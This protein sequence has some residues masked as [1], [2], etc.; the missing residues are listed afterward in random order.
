MFLLNIKNIH[1]HKFVVDKPIIESTSP[2][3]TKIGASLKENVDLVC[4]A[5]GYPIPDIQWNEYTSPNSLGNDYNIDSNKMEFGIK[6]TL[7]FTVQESHFSTKFVCKAS[8]N[9]GNDQVI[10]QVLKKGE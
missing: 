3:Q 4:E 9:R 1:F 8:N 7:S 6:S 10:F 2:S 5:E